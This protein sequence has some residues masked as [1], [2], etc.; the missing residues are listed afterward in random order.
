MRYGVLWCCS[1]WMALSLCSAARAQDR[2]LLMV[3]M[4]KVTWQDLR[5]EGVEAP[6]FW[7]L[8]RRS[9]VGAMCVRTAAGVEGGGGYLTLGAGSRA[10]VA[11]S[12]W[13]ERDLEGYAFNADESADGVRASAAFRAY[14]GWS[15]G[16][17]RIVHL[18]MGELLQ[19]NLRPGYS[20]RLGLLGETL[21]RAGLRVA[22]LGNADTG[23]SV[24]REIAAIG[25]DAQGRVALGDVGPGLRKRNYAVPYAYSTDVTHLYAAFD[26]VASRAHVVIVDLGETSRAEEY[27]GLVPPETAA[28]ARARA[29]AQADRTLAGLLRR[30]PRKVWSVLLLTPT[31]PA[32]TQ[33]RPFS[34]L[35]PVIFAAPGGEAAL[36]TSPSTRR[37]GL[38]VNTDVAATVLNYFGLPAPSDTVG[39]SI[40]TEPER[41][42]AV[43]SLMEDLARNDALEPARHLVFRTF[44]VF[45]AVVL[46]L[47]VLLFILGEHAPGWARALARGLLLVCLSAPVA[48]LLVGAYPDPMSPAQMEAALAALSLVLA[49][50][51][52][53]ST[54]WRAGDGAVSGTLV[55]L[56]VVDLA[57]AQPM[58]QWSTLSY[59]AVAGAR[60]YGL[61]NE[62]GGALLG[63]GLVAAAA[64]LQG[65]AGNSRA[66]RTLIAL[67]LFA[68][69]AVAGWPQLGANLGISL[70][71]ALGF[72]VFATYLLRHRFSWVDA[73]AIAIAVLG[74]ATLIFVADAFLTKGR[75]ASHLGLLLTTIQAQ[76]LSAVAE[77]VVRKLTMNAMLLRTSLWTDLALAASAVLVAAVV[78]RPVALADALRPRPWMTPAVVSCVIG[79]AAA[80]VLNDSGILAAAMALLYGAG[81]LAYLGLGQADRPR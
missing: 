78:V 33:E 28:R 75:T 58:L 74:L 2:K 25:M 45:A 15:V 73:V 42:D 49:F 67:T 29:I 50:L 3:V 71:C 17:N 8:A 43:A 68:L 37:A 44:A 76:G 36:L 20:L 54:G 31:A 9:A 16:G 23:R 79:A 24:H 38:V 70:S 51:L 53:A 35:T 39:R 48:A 22:C 56:L 27:A 26:R 62:Y 11:P 59:S 61:G 21:R 41:V 18:R 57:I 81:A 64:V 30:A 46:W 12:R 77:V 14:T 55:A 63:G 52:A 80:L 65:Q 7:E 34:A 5:A 60:F 19:Q 32:P 66:W 13:R 10:S 69:A 4:D 72:A 1:M 47:S 6:A 40:T